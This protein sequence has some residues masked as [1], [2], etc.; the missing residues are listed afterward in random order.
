MFVIYYRY[1]SEV[2]RE[3]YNFWKI[4]YECTQIK[5]LRFTTFQNSL[6]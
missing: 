6:N 1:M 2:S 4:L 3:A 5:D